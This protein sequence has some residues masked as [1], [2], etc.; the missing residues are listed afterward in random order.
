MSPLRLPRWT[1]LL[2]LSLL[3]GAV[4]LMHGL[5]ASATP[6]GHAGAS[7]LPAVHSHEGD[8]PS[9]HQEAGCD[10]CAVG[11]VVAACVAIVATVVGL[12][13]ARRPVGARVT[14]LVDTATG[15]IRA[16]GRLPRPPDPAWVRLAVMRC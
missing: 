6:T 13:L 11:H 10:G 8:T 2:V 1:A 16:A 4:L 12:R 14:T 15:R 3:A 7:V 5:D 9:A